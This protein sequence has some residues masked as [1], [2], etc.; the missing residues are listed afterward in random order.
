M[1]LSVLLRPKKLSFD[2]VNL[3]TV[4]KFSLAELEKKIFQ[5]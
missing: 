3:R 4:Q 1:E 2:D 5:I